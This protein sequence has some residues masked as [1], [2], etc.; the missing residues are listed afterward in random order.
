MFANDVMT[1]PISLTGLPSISVPVHVDLSDEEGTRAERTVGLQVFGPKL[2]EEKV[3]LA[4]SVLGEG[5]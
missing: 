3:L 2:S 4:A 5:R 1:V